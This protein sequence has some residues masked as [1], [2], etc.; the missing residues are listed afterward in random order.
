M[1]PKFWGD[2]TKVTPHKALKFI[3][4]CQFNFDERDVPHR[5][6][7]RYRGTSLIR[8]GPTPRITIGP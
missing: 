7:C 2:V 5:A 4:W 8:N 1:T 6:V 3:V